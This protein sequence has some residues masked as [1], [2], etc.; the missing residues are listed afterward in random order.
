MEL[1]RRRR[2]L[3]K[4]SS[5]RLAVL[6]KKE[7]RM[8]G[9]AANSSRSRFWPFKTHHWHYPSQAPAAGPM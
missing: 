6:P 5:K 7:S 3:W 8:P 4:A 2:R 1:A 9:M